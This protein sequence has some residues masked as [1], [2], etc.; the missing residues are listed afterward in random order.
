MKRI[1]I[2]LSVLLALSVCFLSLPEREV[3]ASETAGG[4][5]RRERI[6]IGCFVGEEY[7]YFRDQFAAGLAELS[8]M[9]LLTDYDVNGDY[10]TSQE[11]WEAACQAGSAGETELVFSESDFYDYSVMS[12]GEL[13]ELLNNDRIDLMLVFGTVAGK[14]LT[15][16]SDAISYDYMVFAATDPIS[17][18]IVASETERFNEKSFAQMDTGLI[19]RQI[20]GACELFT[21]YDVGVVYEDSEAAY[22]YSGIGQLKE[23]AEE[24]GFTIHERHVDESAGG[25]DDA[26]YY[27][28]LKA[29]YDDLQ[30][31]ID[32]LYI[33][34]ATI[35]SDMLPSLLA[36]IHEA[37]IITIGQSDETEV[38]MG[39][40]M[41]ISSDDPVEEGKFL[42]HVLEEY[43]SGTPV[44]QIEQV[45]TVAPKIYFNRGTIEKTGVRLPLEMY[46]AADEIFP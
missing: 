39:V 16:N 35:D 20:K 36:D 3:F 19:S 22:S 46:L 37:G 31:E 34:T 29:A 38:E 13:N 45:F 25:E 28:E 8:D 7:Y 10:G 9:G 32:T 23:A 11:V 27:R 15:D 43:A 30:D 12:D 24:Y 4:T 26:R 41:Y 18:G 17:S 5:V 40:L 21:I 42:A 33:T 6:V 14:F 1:T 44:T 2:C